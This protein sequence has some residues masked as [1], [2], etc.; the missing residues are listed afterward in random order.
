MAF[1]GRGSDAHARGSRVQHGA[2]VSRCRSRRGWRSLDGLGW[3]S[4]QPHF[5]NTRLKTSSTSPGA[6]IWFV[7]LEP[8]RL[9]P[10]SCLL[11]A[12]LS[13]VACVPVLVRVPE[14]PS[15]FGR[16]VARSWA[17][18]T[19]IVVL[20]IWRSGG[21][22]PRCTVRK[23]FVTRAGGLPGSSN[24]LRRTVIG[25]WVMDGHGTETDQELDGILFISEEGSVLWEGLGSA[26]SP[27]EVRGTITTPLAE[28]LSEE[29]RSR[30]DLVA[31]SRLQRSQ[32]NSH[33]EHQWSLCFSALEGPRLI[34]GEPLRREMVGVLERL[35][36]LGR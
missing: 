17:P 1:L 3:P 21:L 4:A 6:A 15:P 2:R 36:E 11:L 13:A 10:F 19:M 29:I 7:R 14:A 26:S 25:V 32:R 30:D 28:Q 24:T 34:A 8:L 18:S 20:P 5:H 33:E 31:L 16:S 12:L 22:S 9:L 23:P 27:R 35:Q